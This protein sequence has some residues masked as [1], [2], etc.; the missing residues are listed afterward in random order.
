MTGIYCIENSVNRKKYV[1]QAKDIEKRWETHKAE[2]RRGAHYN[3]HLQ[4]AWDK[5]G[6]QSFA[7]YILEL[8][9]VESLSER[10]TF[11]INSLSSFENGYNMTQG[12]EG[13]RG[14]HH[15]EEHKNKMRELFKGRV[16]SDETLKRM[17]EAGKGRE[18]KQTESR[19]AGYKVVAEKLKG[20]PFS[21]EHRKRLSEAHKGKPTWNKGMK[22]SPEEHAMY[23]K[24]HSDSTKEKI[25]NA[26]RG[27]K[28]TEEQRL[29]CARPVSCVE[30]GEIFPSI[31]DAA[32][33]YGVSIYAIS[34]VLR[35]KAKTCQK[36][37]WRYAEGSGES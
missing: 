15:T 25:G 9:D 4:A 1:G 22:F 27:R 17:S 24:H 36:R 29:K 14:H 3:T 10:E 7:F 19:I 8:C 12:G 13:T 30:T 11:Y 34:N 28:R 5:Y 37:H 2:L 16:F 32:K 21:E 18:Q 35:G 23:G 33:A 20:R 6:E 26:N 31:T